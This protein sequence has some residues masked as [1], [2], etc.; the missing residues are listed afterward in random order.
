[1][2]HVQGE[3]L[4]SHDEDGVRVIDSIRVT[5]VAYHPGR[6]CLC[7]HCQDDCI[8]VTASEYCGDCEVRHGTNHHICH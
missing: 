1:M 5:S 7:Q 2:Y 8:A 4:R 6:D 3:V